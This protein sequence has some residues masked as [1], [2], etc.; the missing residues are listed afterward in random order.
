MMRQAT[1]TPSFR[2]FR[3]RGSALIAATWILIVLAAMALVLAHRMRVETLASANQLSA[4]QADALERAGEQFVLASLDNSNG[5]SVTITGIATEAIPV[6]DG[7]FWILRPNGD[8]PQSYAFGITD[9]SSKI[10]LNTATSDTLLMLN[11]GIT[12][13]IADS[14]VMWRSGVNTVTQN[15]AGDSYYM[16]LPGPY[17]CKNSKFESVEELL[18]IRDVTPDLLYGPD[19]NHNGVLDPAEMAATA[20]TTTTTLNTNQD[21]PRGIYNFLTVYSVTPTKSASGTTPIDINSPNTNALNK[22]LTTNLSAS[23]AAAILR[24]VSPGRGRNT[25]FLNLF[26]FYFRT[27]LN[28]T[29]FAKIADGLTVTTAAHTGLINVN[30]APR[31]V[32]RCLP[33]LNDTDATALISA[34]QG[35]TD[36]T[37]T[38][39]WLI[40]VL[41][42]DKL[43]GIGNSITGRSTSYSADIVGVSGDGRAY[44]RVRIVVNAAVSPPVIL[45]RKD[46]T[47]QGWPLDPVIRTTLRSG[48][49]LAATSTT[50]TT[51]QTPIRGGP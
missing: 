33:G 17:H 37:N 46:L 48:Q 47:D 6:G 36:S 43:V 49:G 51:L 11:S 16:S 44:K 29:E 3:Q 35:I 20:T 27:G 38:L 40:N 7:Y 13:A 14:I 2:R 26:D 1:S 9:E 50:T 21:D 18:L 32:L 45:F 24:I 5:D 19:Q 34:R 10:N 31:V 22:Y 4:Y 39:A 28:A 8:D 42:R 25:L 15:G 23:R 41:S 30:T 12:N